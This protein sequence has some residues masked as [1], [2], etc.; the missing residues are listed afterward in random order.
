M[1]SLAVILPAAGQS[2]RFGGPRNKLLENLG[3]KTVLRRSIEAFLAV[4]QVRR[5][6]IATSSE[7]MV[8]EVALISDGRVRMCA[9]GAS[10]AESV[11]NGVGELVDEGGLEWVGVHDAARP[12][13]SR[14]LIERT[15]SAAMEHGAAAPA[16]AVSLTIKEATGPLPARIQRTVPR[17]NLWAMQTP[18]I[19][20]LVDLQGAFARCPIPLEAVTDD[21]QLLELDG[22][23]AWLVPGEERNIKLTT[24]GDLELA[25]RWVE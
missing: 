17:Q 5:I 15:L 14:E 19:M 22:K 23:E 10:R 3:G 13:V 4:D 12:L 8:D 16:L 1:Q 6:V 7:A 25:E 24:R 21:V 20:R 9:G 18:Q 2:T 11:R